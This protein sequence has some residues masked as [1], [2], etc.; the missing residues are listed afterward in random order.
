MVSLQTIVVV[1]ADWSYFS[2]MTDYRIP[3]F[4]PRDPVRMS[5]RDWCLSLEIDRCPLTAAQRRST[6]T[7]RRRSSQ[8]IE[9]GASR[10]LC[11]AAAATTS[12]PCPLS[13][14]CLSSF[15]RAFPAWAIR[16]WSPFPS[17][18]PSFCL[19]IPHHRDPGRLHPSDA[20]LV[21]VS[22]VQILKTS[23]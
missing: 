1:A 22:R 5:P 21:T 8:V 23:R 11:P 9:R 4:V 12:T 14:S 3:E 2:I 6:R 20:V 19:E 15:D 17:L 16:E 10:G 18:N 13:G 7:K